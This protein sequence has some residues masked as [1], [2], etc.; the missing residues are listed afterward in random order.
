VLTK[1]Q[2]KNFETHYLAGH[3]LALV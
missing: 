1:R 2:E 3:C